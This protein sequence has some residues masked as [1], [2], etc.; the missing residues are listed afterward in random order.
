[1]STITTDKYSG[2]SGLATGELAKDMRDVASDLSTLLTALTAVAGATALASTADVSETAGVADGL[3]VGTPTTASS[4]A[5]DPGGAT[6]WNVN[7]SAGYAFVNSVGKYNAAQVDVN[8]STGSKIM[9]IGQAMY[10]WIVWK[11]ASGTVSQQVVL[12]TAATSGSE[13]IPSNTDI[14]TAVTH[15]RWIKLALCHA[16]RS[17]DEVVATTQDSSYMAKWA[18]AAA[19]LVNELKTKYNLMAD[20]VNDVSALAGTL[21]TK[22]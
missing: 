7:I 8:V 11:E 5:A 21:L 6:D 4:Q 3:I 20:K 12:G 19:T 10:A 18:G 13:T 1:M 14:T 22:V 16:H 15:A 9:T 2:G 17:A